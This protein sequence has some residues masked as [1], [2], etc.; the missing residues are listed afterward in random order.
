LHFVHPLP[1]WLAV[2]LA[3]AVGA[4]AY[5]EY[6]R[7]LAPLTSVQRGVLVGLRT[8]AL[9]ALL[10]FMFRPIVLLPPASAH[11]A[12]VPVLIDVSRSRRLADA[13]GQ[14]RLA[15]ATALLKS[16]LL[17]ELSRQFTPEIYSVGEGLAPAS[18][19]RL[20][21]DARQT[22]LAGALTAVRERYRGQRVAGI[23]V[24][25]DGGDTG[26]QNAQDGGREGAGTANGPPV[27]AIGI[28]SA[29]GLHDREVLG[30]NA[31]EQRL[32]QASVDLHVSAISYGFGRT[33]FLLRV[34]ANGRVLDSRRIVPPADGSPISEV[35]T[36]SPDPLNPTVYPRRFRPTKANRSPKQRAG[37]LVSPA[38]RKRRLL[39]VEGAPGSSTAS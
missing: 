12:V 8:L 6:R 21:A 24:L 25:S 13:D 37:V 29:E 26:Q 27:F 9:V 10:L 34:L 1:W 11:E 35:F 14:A 22:D 39:V 20:S 30:I 33:P 17:P 15:R 2:L 32:D 4:M 28:G 16:Q 18:V 23:V 3:A 38:G 5:V 19:D 31:G 7:P 36:V